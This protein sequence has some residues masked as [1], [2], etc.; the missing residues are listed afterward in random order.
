MAEV[1]RV[2]RERAPRAGRTSAKASENSPSDDADR[3]AG[4]VE[5]YRASFKRYASECLRIQTKEPGPLRPLVPNYTQRVLLS[6]INN[7][8]KRGIPPRLIVLKSRQVGV[9]TVTEALIFYLTHLWPNRNGL[10]LSH[11]D[12]ATRGLFRMTRRFHKHMPKALQGKTSLD[13]VR[14]IQFENE[15]RLQVETAGDARS[16]TAH[17]IHLSELAFMENARLTLDAV[18]QSVPQSTDSLVVIEST[19]NGA[20]NEFHRVWQQSVRKEGE[21][22]MHGL[23]FI[24]IFIPWYKHEEYRRA[25]WFHADD[26][27]PEEVLLQKQFDLS[28]DQLAWRRWCVETNCRGDE[29]VFQVEYPSTP[30]EAFLVSGRPVVD[31]RATAFY[32]KRLEVMPKQPE[33][34]EVDLDEKKKRA[35]LTPATRGRC[36]IYVDP[37]E[38]HR[39]IGGADPSEGDAGSDPSPLAFVD[40]MTMGLVCEWF[41]KAP[42][43]LLARYAAALGYHFGRVNECACDALIAGEANNHGI[44]FHSTLLGLG[45]PNIY[46]G[47]SSEESVDGKVIKKPGWYQTSKAKHAIFNTV[48]KG[49]REKWSTH[50]DQD[51]LEIPSRI[52]VKQIAALQYKRKESRTGET[53]RLTTFIVP[54]DPSDPEVAH[55]DLATAYAIALHIHRGTSEAPLEPLPMRFPIES[56]NEILSAMERDPDRASALLLDV[57]GLTCDQFVEVLKKRDR[58]KGAAGPLAGM[59]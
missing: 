16:Y 14:E 58:L 59:G 48:R 28:L 26:L 39:Y 49:A 35:I 3:E 47:R 10:V 25:P 52:L 57:A 50:G 31:P 15:S 27:T 29:Q 23:G 36:R 54:N 46:F 21:A 44:Q 30:D 56:V 9:S 51:I 6:T 22:R 32:Y 41:G 5:E 34:F 53:D 11:K 13:N 12:Q 20:G 37:R 1:R 42:P 43:D 2:A 45:Y 4:S 55:V 33:N 38:R 8:R 40:Q 19:A 24:P 18:L 17:Y 7:C